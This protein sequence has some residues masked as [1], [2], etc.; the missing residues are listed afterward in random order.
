[1]DMMIHYLLIELIMMG[2]YSP[3]N[4]RW[5]PMTIQANNKRD[6][7][8]ITAN[9]ETYTLAQWEAA[10]GINQ[11][12]IRRRLNSGYIPRDC[13][14][15]PTPTNHDCVNAIYFVDEYNN[16]INQFDKE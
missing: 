12:T 5:V 16:P 13:I 3:D 10:S 7:V 2:P 6:S 4:C 8:Y 9:G 15:T 11:N 1:M 14:Y